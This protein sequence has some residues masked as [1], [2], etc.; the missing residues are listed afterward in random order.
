MSSRN[1]QELIERHEAFLDCAPSDRPLIGYWMGGYFPAEQFPHGTSGWQEKQV[2]SP[3]DVRLEQFAADYERLYRI[4]RDAEDDFFYVGSAYWGIPWLE[5]ILGCKVAAGKTTCWAE[6]WLNSLDEIPARAGDLDNNGWFR[7]LMGFTRELVELSAGRFPVCAPL[8]RGLGDAANAMRG[9]MNMVMEYVDDPE[10]V[11]RLLE[12]CATVRQ[13]VVGRL[14]EVIPAWHGTYAAG[15]YPS[16]VWS[17]R[18]VAYHQEDSTA[19]LSPEL[20]HEFLV[21]LEKR[22]CRAAEVNF[23]HLHSSCLWPVDVLLEEDWCDVLEINIDHAGAGPSLREALPVLKKIQAARRPLL[24]WGEIGEAD[25][26]LL[27]EELTPAGLSIQ[28]I[29]NIP[30]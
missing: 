5:A 8:L 3:G 22:M 13:E 26:E 21:P 18:R 27:Y 4:H 2:L 24:L 16:K 29:R 14:G 10:G 28:P 6:P 9:A 15:G 7:C 11:R 19:L 20:F 17:R 1:V 30:V 12:H 25:M 23:F